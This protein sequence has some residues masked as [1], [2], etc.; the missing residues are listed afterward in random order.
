MRQ[1]DVPVILSGLGTVQALNT[2]AI[3][4]QVTGQLETVDFTEG[5]SVHKGDKLAQIDQRPAQARLDQANAQLAKDQAQL[6]NVQRNLSRN[7]PLLRNGF[8]TD[9]QVTDQQSQ[10]A[11]LQSAMQADQA[12][13]EDARTQLSYTTLTAPFDG[14]TGL[15][16]LDVGNIIHPTDVTGLTVETQIQPIGVVFTL[17]AAD[18]QQVMDGMAKGDLKAVAYDQAGTRAL[19]TGRLLLINNQADPATGTVQLKA[20]FPN[21]SRRLWPGTFVNVELATSVA[22]GALTLPTDAVQ[23]GAKGPFVF[24][25]GKDG[26]VASRTIQMGQ[27]QHDMVIVTAGLRVGDDVVEQGQYRLVDG[28]MVSPAGAGQVVDASAA[29]SGMLP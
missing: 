3:R 5:L 22:E 4:S 9:Q 20:L 25:I 27:R 13:I 19:D 1:Q 15:R 10:V 8:A 14:I 16:T 24:V 7:L 18:I 23:Q 2:A 28:S 6:A 12:V 11:Q 17:P 21:P 29:S 26:K